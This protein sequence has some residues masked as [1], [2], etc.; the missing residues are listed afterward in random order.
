M[1]VCC[2]HALQFSTY[3]KRNKWKSCFG[4]SRVLLSASQNTH[5][6]RGCHNFTCNIFEKK[7]GSLNWQWIFLYVYIVT[8]FNYITLLLIV[9]TIR[10]RYILQRANQLPYY[11]IYYNKLNP[12]TRESCPLLATDTN[13]TNYLYLTVTYLHNETVFWYFYI[14]HPEFQVSFWKSLNIYRQV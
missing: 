13:L 2:S 10:H 8:H 14:V 5:F 9:I 4:F 1:F 6:N 3:L 11:N 7:H 12:V